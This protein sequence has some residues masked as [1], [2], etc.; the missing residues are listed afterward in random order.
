MLLD[1]IIPLVLGILYATLS[2]TFWSIEFLQSAMFA[3]SLLSLTATANPHPQHIPKLPLHRRQHTFHDTRIHAPR[4]WRDNRCSM[5]CDWR[6]INLC[7]E[8]FNVDVGMRESEVS[9]FIDSQSPSNKG[10]GCR[11]ILHERS[12]LETDLTLISC[13]ESREGLLL[14]WSLDW[15]KS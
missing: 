4:C 9:L 15:Y 6:R 5:F 3:N 8:T 14:F 10:I 1:L 11:M 2:K 12:W 13:S 7:G